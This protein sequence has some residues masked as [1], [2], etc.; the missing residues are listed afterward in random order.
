LT[1]YFYVIGRET[2][3]TDRSLLIA[4]IVGT[5]PAVFFGLLLENSMDTVFRNTDLVAYALLVGSAIFVLAE[6]VST[7]KKEKLSLETIGWKKGILIGLFQSIAL[8]PGM[9]RS[10]MTISGGLFFGLTREAA[11]RFGFL[12]S[13]PIIFGSGIKKIFE[14]S[15][16]GVLQSYEMPLLFGT[17]VAFVSGLA[18]IHVLLMFVRTQPL[19]IFA[20]Y[21]VLLAFALLF[22][23][24]P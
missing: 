23:L 9:S 1:G 22:V 5:I 12:L 7:Q 11:A 13:V 2:Q 8:I 14:L 21:R 3:S 17:V 6:Y 24:F 19:Y 10:G 16:T 15:G 18:S 4:L 20:L